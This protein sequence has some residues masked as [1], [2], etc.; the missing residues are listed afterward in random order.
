MIEPKLIDW[1]ELGDSMQKM[2]IYTNSY[3]INYFSFFRIM[4]KYK[5]D[6]LLLLFFLKIYFYFQFMMIP[7]IQIPDEEIKY[8]TLLEFLTSIKKNNF[9]TR[10]NRFKK[11][12]FNFN[13]Y[14]FYIL[15]IFDFTSYLFNVKYQ[16]SKNSTSSNEILKFI[17]FILNQCFF[18]SIN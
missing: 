18:V 16:K 12:I 6:K 5:Q 3:L 13:K 14:C 4:L 9:Y 17:K 8:D 11:I 15:F 10:Y 7:V 2:Y 1:V